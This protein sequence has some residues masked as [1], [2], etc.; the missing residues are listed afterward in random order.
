VQL[1][2]G[3]ATSTD[4]LR[5]HCRSLISAYKVPKDILLVERV[6]RTPVSKV[7]YRASATVAA[8][9]LEART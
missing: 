9:L 6:P 3:A 8:E 5:E 1:R 7:D 4:A 2:E